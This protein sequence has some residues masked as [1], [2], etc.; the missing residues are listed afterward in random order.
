VV[1]QWG[2][3][4]HIVLPEQYALTYYRQLCNNLFMSIVRKTR[5][6]YNVQSN[7]IG[8]IRE[9]FVVCYSTGVIRFSSKSHIPNQNAFIA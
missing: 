4:Q 8:K 7:L 1:C 9:L 2:F 3:V 6:T 5:L